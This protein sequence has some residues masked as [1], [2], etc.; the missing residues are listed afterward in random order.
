M[1]TLTISIIAAAVGVGTAAAQIPNNG[2]ENWR[3]VNQVIEPASWYGP[4]SL[5]DSSGTYSAVSRST[6]HYPASV[7]S[8]S[9]RIA[10]DTSLWKSLSPPASFLGWGFLTSTQAGDRP[11]FVVQGH[12]SSLRGYYKFIPQNGD[13]MNITVFLYKDGNEVASGLIR[14][15]VEQASWTSFTVAISSYTAAD[16]ARISLTAANEPKE[17]KTGPRGNSV[18]YVDNLSFDNLIVSDVSWSDD[19]YPESA[20]LLQNY[21][22]PFNPTTEIRYQTS[23]VS[24]VRL[25]VHDLLGREVAVLVDEERPSGYCTARWDASG[26]P[27]GV[28]FYTIRAGPFVQ[29]K[30][31]VMIK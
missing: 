23:E 29:T 22:N 27:S 15:A 10:N 24:H 25:T 31:M 1:R 14:S 18:L 21:P 3:T 17:G 26:V 16:S 7:G 20:A 8:Y 30:R 28:Y 6:D 12:P 9:V 13:T 2:F 11:L 5:I 4:Y 19:A